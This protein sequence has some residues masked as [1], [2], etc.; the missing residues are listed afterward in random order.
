MFNPFKN[1]SNLFENMFDPF[2]NLL[3]PFP[4][5]SFLYLIFFLLNPVQTC[6]PGEASGG[7]PSRAGVSR[8]QTL[9]EGGRVCH[10]DEYLV[11]PQT[12]KPSF[13]L[14]ILKYYR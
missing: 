12:L 1:V 7:G 10:V 6:R 8:V 3:H 2:K 4:V 9:G 5:E 13:Y 11:P 14:R